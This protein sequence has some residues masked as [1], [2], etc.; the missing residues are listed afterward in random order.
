MDG[1]EATARAMAGNVL[2]GNA[3]LL[4]LPLEEPV[5]SALFGAPG[6][7]SVYA[8]A[9]EAN[10]LKQFL[11]VKDIFKNR[12][13]PLL[14]EARTEKS[15]LFSS[16]VDEILKKKY[17]G[18]E[19]SMSVLGI[20]EKLYDLRS[21]SESSLTL[22]VPGS[23]YNLTI[24]KDVVLEK[25]GFTTDKH[26]QETRVT[27]RNSEAVRCA[28]TFSN[29]VLFEETQNRS[30]SFCKGVSKNTITSNNINVNPEASILSRQLGYNFEDNR[31]F[32]LL[33][34][35][36]ITV[37]SGV[38]AKLQIL[39]AIKNC[40]S[41]SL[42]RDYPG[43]MYKVL[44]GRKPSAVI[45]K[46]MLIQ[47]RLTDIVGCK[48]EQRPL[49][50]RPK[51]AYIDVLGLHNKKSLLTM[52]LEALDKQESVSLTNDSKKK[53]EKAALNSNN[54]SDSKFSLDHLNKQRRKVLNV[55][56]NSRHQG[57]SPSTE[58]NNDIDTINSIYR[59]LE[60]DDI[61]DN[62]NDDDDD[63][64]LELEAHQI[65]T[66]MAISRSRPRSAAPFTHRKQ[67][68]SSLSNNYIGKVRM[69]QSEPEFSILLLC[70]RDMM[71]YSNSLEKL[72]NLVNKVT[73]GS[74]IDER[75]NK[76]TSR[77]ITKNEPE[78]N[79]NNTEK[80][81]KENNSLDLENQLNDI[82]SSGL[83]EDDIQEIPQEEGYQQVTAGKSDNTSET[84]HVKTFIN[85]I[86][87]SEDEKKEVPNEISIQTCEDNEKN[88]NNKTDNVAEGNNTCQCE[89]N[90]SEGPLGSSYISSLNSD[91]H[92][93][94]QQNEMVIP[95]PEKE[96]SAISEIIREISDKN[97]DIDHTNNSKIQEELGDA[98]MDIQL[99]NL[100]LLTLFSI[101]SPSCY[102]YIMASDQLCPNI[103]SI[104]KL[105]NETFFENTCN[106][107]YLNTRFREV[108][109][110]FPQNG[111]S[112]GVSN[113]E[114]K[115]NWN[116][117]PLL[118][119]RFSSRWS[120]RNA[121]KSISTQK[122][123]STSRGQQRPVTRG[124]PE[125]NTNN[126]MS[127]VLNRTSF[128]KSNT[129]ETEK[130]SKENWSPSNDNLPNKTPIR[131]DV[132]D[133]EDD[134]NSPGSTST[135]NNDNSNNNNN[136]NKESG[137]GLLRSLI[138]P[139]YYVYKSCSTPVREE[140]NG[141]TIKHDTVETYNLVQEINATKQLLQREL[142]REKAL[143]DEINDRNALENSVQDL[144][145]NI[146]NLNRE[147]EEKIK[148]HQNI[149]TNLNK[150]A[151]KTLEYLATTIANAYYQHDSD[152]FQDDADVI[153]ENIEV[154][155][156]YLERSGIIYNLSKGLDALNDP[157]QLTET[158][159]VVGT[160]FAEF[161]MS[162]Y[163]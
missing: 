52:T 60:K 66:K 44:Y 107:K 97:Y 70:K 46:S 154:M 36:K 1:L 121:S 160:A 135:T 74:V 55:R 72:V 162:V 144:G 22:V 159:K 28:N 35:T 90:C 12:H 138:L 110:V 102:K 156:E 43:E 13:S 99:G 30:G 9:L 77:S 106:S 149:E 98:I 42:R 54:N 112:S 49:T 80:S 108:M 37:K 133:V 64:E 18:E 56:A 115:V 53:S 78:Q 122:R 142:D 91:S 50:Q 57:N 65:N 15:C 41:L 67:R 126:K 47:F 100:E 11:D 120:S 6:L 33:G 101:I 125:Q 84:S 139:K 137:K 89:D 113:T 146:S 71:S 141:F 158:L 20:D 24:E 38:T 34:L 136:N 73:K 76:S 151:L 124:S 118:S 82:K 163:K 23:L 88:L 105:L 26:S 31:F 93:F 5:C 51:Q 95:P 32:R 87:I 85:N 127:N 155:Y 27:G 140:N 81:N 96:C 21:D 59:A 116:S 14:K 86:T 40:F 29:S 17:K 62:N 3:A 69:V 109:N 10:S 61:Y 111:I 145:N 123:R 7:E 4:V 48:S 130:T 92:K 129:F 153:Y 161:I 58:Q 131:T 128:Q 75:L 150:E 143:D 157:E 63:D 8:E 117:P 103:S 39:E 68:Q 2:N 25:S 152:L 134:N 45:N 119:S 79:N 132:S 104:Q 148:E 94:Q 19:L 83:K 147:I 16:L 114:K